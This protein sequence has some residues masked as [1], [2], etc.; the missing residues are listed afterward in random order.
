MPKE[1]YL[2]SPV[3]DFVAQDLIASIQEFISEEVTLRVNTPGGSVFSTWGIIAK[4]KEHGNVSIKVD[5]AAMS[6]GANMLLYATNVEALDVSKFL[7]HRA[8]MYV[9]NPE[10]QAFLDDI[11]KDL[12]AKMK[13]KI[14]AAKFKEITDYSID[15]LFDSTKRIDVVLSAKEMKE[16]GIVTKINKLTPADV[17]AFNNKMFAVAASVA[18]SVEAKEEV[19]IEKPIIKINKMTIE[20]LKA[21]HPELFNSIIALGVAKEKD[22]TGAWLAFVDVDAEAVSKGI[23]DGVELSATAMAELSRKSFSAKALKDIE[24]DS[25]K[26]VKTEEVKGKVD[27]KADAVSAFEAE[28]RKDLKLSK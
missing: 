28:A 18:A 17:T 22:R 19:K 25:T 15:E 21:E 24:A 4:M 10:D 11:N 20:A 2:Y 26:D 16:I 5:G 8:D 23:K 27:S 12:K 14:N 13:M 6:S 9:A 3:Y 7:F 1:L